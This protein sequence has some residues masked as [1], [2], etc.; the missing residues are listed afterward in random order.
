[1]PFQMPGCLSWVWT[2][3]Q[4]FT[5]E[6]TAHLLVG[7]RPTKRHNILQ[8]NHGLFDRLQTPGSVTSITLYRPPRTQTHCIHTDDSYTIC[9]QAAIRRLH[10]WL[11]NYN[12]PRFHYAIVCLCGHLWKHTTVRSN[13]SRVWILLLLMHVDTRAS[14][15]H[16]S[17]AATLRHAINIGRQVN[18]H[19]PQLRCLSGRIVNFLP[20]SELTLDQ[21]IGRSVQPCCRQ[22]D[23]CLAAS[24]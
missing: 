5:V 22:S 7:R 19:G 9:T 17:P 6:R 21:V 14:T 24:P 8:R 2:P 20:W 18:I 3:C 4:P 13:G 10:S 15:K 12:S 23:T 11:E 16:D 1:M